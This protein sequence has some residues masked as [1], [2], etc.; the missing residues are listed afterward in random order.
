[1]DNNKT[2][3]FV[4]LRSSVHLTALAILLDPPTIPFVRFSL[5]LSQ[6][7]DSGTKSSIYMET[8]TPKAS[9]K[10]K[11]L[12]PYIGVITKLAATISEKPIGQDT[13]LRLL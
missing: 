11:Y 6:A 7:G 13:S 4:P 12:Q 10:N 2:L 5:A 9:K 1:M 3:R 8:I